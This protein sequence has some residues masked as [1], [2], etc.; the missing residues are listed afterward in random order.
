MVG[1]NCNTLR[2]EGE[3]AISI[4]IEIVLSNWSRP[5]SHE[6]GQFG[7]VREDRGQKEKPRPIHGAW[8]SIG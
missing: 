6:D 2:G 8:E 7:E 5:R 4:P 1:V 3:K